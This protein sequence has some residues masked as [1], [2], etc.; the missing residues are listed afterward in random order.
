MEILDGG[1]ALQRAAIRPQRSVLAASKS[2]IS[3]RTGRRR[4]FSARNRKPGFWI[5]CEARRPPGKS[6]AT[7]PPRSICAPTRKISR[8][9]SP[10]RGPAPDMRLRAGRSQHG[11]CG[12]RRNL[13]FCARPRHHRLRHR[14]RRPPQ[15]LGRTGREVAAARSL[16]RRSAWLSSPAR[17]RPRVSSKRWSTTCRKTIRCGRSTSDKGRRSEAQ[18][19]M[20]MLL[21]HGVRSCLEYARSGDIC[22]RRAPCPIPIWRRT[23]RLSIWAATAIR[24]CDVTSDAIGNGIRVHSAPARAERATGWRAAAAIG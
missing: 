9:G 3:A 19:T 8:R 13:R 16:S 6:G 21:R 12:A 11:V 1:S 17:S 22:Q 14:R 4:P 5:A 15:L 20:N 18:P 24:W 23:F 10:S 2:P 7:P